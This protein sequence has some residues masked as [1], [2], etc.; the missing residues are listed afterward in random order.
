MDYGGHDFAADTG[1]APW[2]QSN[3]NLRD[4]VGKTIGKHTLHF[5]FDG[6]FV[7]QNELSGVAGALRRSARLAN[8]PSGR[9][10]GF[11]AITAKSGWHSHWAR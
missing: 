2:N 10:S 8:V 5:G 4:D 1:F 11:P 7:Q 9:N 3:L 6:I